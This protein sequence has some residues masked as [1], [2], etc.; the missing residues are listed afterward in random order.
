MFSEEFSKERFSEKKEMIMSMFEEDDTKNQHY[1]KAYK[2]KEFVNYRIGH[3]HVPDCNRFASAAADMVLSAVYD[4]PA[5][6]EL[7]TT[8]FDTL[9]DYCSALDEVY[10]LVN[11]HVQQ[12]VDYSPWTLYETSPFMEQ[13]TLRCAPAVIESSWAHAVLADVVMWLSLSSKNIVQ[14]VDCADAY[15]LIKNYIPEPD[16]KRVYFEEVGKVKSSVGLVVVS[17]YSPSI[18]KWI[19]AAEA[20][21]VL[22]WSP[23]Y[24]RTKGK[25]SHFKFVDDI[26]SAWKSKQVKRTRYF[27]FFDH[28]TIKDSLRSRSSEHAIQNFEMRPWSHI[29][30][31][32]PDL[33]V[34]PGIRSALKCFSIACGYKDKMRSPAS[35]F[36]R[37]FCQNGKPHQI[38]F[39]E[40]SC[41]DLPG[42]KIKDH[43]HWNPLSR[44]SIVKFAIHFR[45]NDITIIYTDGEYRYTS[46]NSMI[47]DP[48]FV[49]DGSITG[50]A[51]K[52]VFRE[53]GDHDWEESKESMFE[54]VTIVDYNFSQ[55]F[56]F[57]GGPFPSWMLQ[58]FVYAGFAWRELTFDPKNDYLCDRLVHGSYVKICTARKTEELCPIM[59]Y[60]PRAHSLPYNGAPFFELMNNDRRSRAHMRDIA[61]PY[62]ML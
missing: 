15:D 32:I 12:N 5:L 44:Q 14:C 10:P 34:S 45:R 47:R 13:K 37:V 39:G 7:D 43:G 53:Y 35:P 26:T 11:V 18:L 6:I 9:D 30:A 17:Y 51:I 52:T 46:N 62:D 28:Q 33:K 4:L 50:Y 55:Q 1:G 27:R 36:Y 16:N 61:G 38:T 8:S 19:K 40:T 31:A 25:H 20:F 60:N 42:F 57:A 59:K 24:T 56:V 48:C 54:V 21:A 22:I 41:L 2:S 3:S 49:G 23:S 29:A 58:V